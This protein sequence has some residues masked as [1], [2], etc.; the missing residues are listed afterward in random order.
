MRKDCILS[1]FIVTEL[2]DLV[3][4]IDLYELLPLEIYLDIDK[5]HA[6]LVPILDQLELCTC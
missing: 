6:A 1:G 2:E 3:S 4:T 5:M